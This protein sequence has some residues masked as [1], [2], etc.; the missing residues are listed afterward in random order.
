MNDPLTIAIEE[1][2]AAGRSTLR[3]HSCGTAVDGDGVDVAL[4][5]YYALCRV[6]GWWHMCRRAPGVWEH[7]PGLEPSEV[8]AH[9]AEIR[10]A[11]RKALSREAVIP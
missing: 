5:A 11:M 3:S 8:E 2:I 4:D 10:A 7:T 9:E 6:R 1:A